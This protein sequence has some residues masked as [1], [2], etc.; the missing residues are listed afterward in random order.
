MNKPVISLCM[1][2]NGVVE[3]V[4]PV[5]ESIYKQKVSLDSYEVVIT[6]NGDNAAF[7]GK[8][9]NYILTH[10]NI[11]YAETKAS[12]FVNE[13]ESYE[14][15][16]GELIKFVN[17]RTLL[18][19]GAVQRL[20][21]FALENIEEKPVVYF[22]NGVLRKEKKEYVYSSFDLFVRN[23]SYWSSWSTGMTIWKSDFDNT[24]KNI[25]EF[26]VLFPHTDILFAERSRSRYIIE[27]SVIFHEMP[28]GNKPKGNYDLYGAFGLEYL[29]IICDLLRDGSITN[30]TFRIVRNDNLGFIAMLYFSYNLRKR[31][32]SYNL[33]GLDQIFGVF[34]TRRQLFF[35]VVEQFFSAVKQ[36]LIPR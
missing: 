35:K 7:K 14:R 3:W 36:K 12:A 9:R 2:T 13:I 21:D 27:N 8:I 5:L 23:L 28:Q 34:Y 17:H 11:V 32:C 1:P 24:G 25:R 19:D 33:Q 29:G 16:S 18:V 20:I 31:Y 30:K 10:P 4:F 6:D 15:A 26:N 22:S